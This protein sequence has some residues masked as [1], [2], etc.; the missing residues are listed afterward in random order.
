MHE[1]FDQADIL[2]PIFTYVGFPEL[3]TFGFINKTWFHVINYLY[4][5]KLMNTI[6]SV[7]FYKECQLRKLKQ[8]SYNQPSTINEVIHGFFTFLVSKGLRIIV[9]Q[10]ND[11]IYLH[12]KGNLSLSHYLYKVFDARFYELSSFH[13]YS[14]DVVILHTLER[15]KFIHHVNFIVDF[16]NFPQIITKIKTIGLSSVTKNSLFSPRHSCIH[17]EN[18]HYLAQITSSN[19]NIDVECNL[20]DN[21]IMSIY[22]IF[23]KLVVDRI[24]L[25]NR[26]IKGVN[27]FNNMYIL[28]YCANVSDNQ[29]FWEIAEFDAKGI[30]IKPLCNK[31]QRHLADGVV[32]E[33]FKI[34]DS[35]FILNFIKGYESNKKIRSVFHLTKMGTNWQI[36][37]VKFIN[38]SPNNQPTLPIKCPISNQI[39]LVDQNLIYHKVELH[40]IE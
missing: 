16:S 24:Q 23:N 20:T 36:L 28:Y 40:L 17:C 37:P 18:S 5:R 7:W 2:I 13:Q 11:S 35:H 39:Y 8:L 4:S 31:C 38:S 10:I 1:I 22:N 26:V 34:T 30:S 32:E 9:S 3:A 29:Y 12:I 19:G 21:N 15:T 33:I 25:I 6:E 27:L 14:D